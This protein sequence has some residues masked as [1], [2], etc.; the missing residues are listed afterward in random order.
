VLLKKKKHFLICKIQFFLQKSAFC[1][2]SKSIS[3]YSAPYKKYAFNVHTISSTTYP[4][5]EVS[6]TNSTN[7][8]C[9]LFI[10]NFTNVSC[11]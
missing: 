8:V 11:V 9:Q 1:M 2:A 7:G 3:L 6:T 10:G 4:M 5:V